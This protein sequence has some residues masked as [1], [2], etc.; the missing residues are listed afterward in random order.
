VLVIPKSASKKATGLELIEMPMIVM[1]S[2]LT[3][4]ALFGAT[5]GTVAH[6]YH[7]AGHAAPDV[8]TR[9]RLGVVARTPGL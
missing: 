5:V 6:G 8:A 7:Q 2:D 1:Q 4:Q 9:S 3:G